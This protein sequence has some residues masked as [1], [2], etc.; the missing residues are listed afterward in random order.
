VLVVDVVDVADAA[1]AIAADENAGYK[2]G[3][4]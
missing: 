4:D 3:G 2:A 1:L